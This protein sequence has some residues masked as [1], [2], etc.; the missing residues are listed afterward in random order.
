M[1]KIILCSGL[2]AALVFT[3]CSSD[4]SN[5][6]NTNDDFYTIVNK[7]TGGVTAVIDLNDTTPLE[8][9]QAVPSVSGQQYPA[10]TPAV[11][12]MNDKV[13][14]STVNENTFIVKEN[15][16]KVGGTISVNEAANGYAIITFMPY[17]T[18][19]DNAN[20]EIN[21]TTGI[22]DDGGQP[23]YQEMSYEYTTY[24]VPSTSLGDAT[25]FENGADGMVFIGDGNI[26]S[27]SLGCLSPFAG[28][29][30][31][32][33]TS[34]DALVSA[35]NAIGGTS[36]AMIL[37]PFD[38]NSASSLSFNYNFLSAEFLEYVGSEFDDSFMAVVVGQNGAHV[39]FVT[40]VNTIGENVTQCEGFPGMPDDGDDYAGFT[41]W[42]SKTI[43][44]GSLTGPVY[45]IFMTTDVSDDIY[46]TVV[47]IDA[48]SLN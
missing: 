5:S 23:L 39:E 4:D 31:A 28:S 25:G 21:L 2:L 45:V 44:F 6:G 7:G 1:K 10:N 22:Q 33:I 15:G 12:F 14:L 43:N 20:V 17:K 36:S 32:A 35:N 30:F 11:F 16:R 9:A 34:G 18:F 48:V 40:S 27:A 42:T 47:G 38:S 46:S 24:S 29:S 3:G 41:G 26:V 19:A 8:V 37:G 13:L